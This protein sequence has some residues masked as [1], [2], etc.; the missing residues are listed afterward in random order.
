[1]IVLA[2]DKRTLINFENFHEV[3][4][5]EENLR[6]VGRVFGN[7]KNLTVILG[8]YTDFETALKEFEDFEES[9]LDDEVVLHEFD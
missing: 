3:F 7:D 1:M 2:Q 9:L 8:Q 6:I 5:D 4:L